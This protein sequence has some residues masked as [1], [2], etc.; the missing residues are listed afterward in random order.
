MLTCDVR[1]TCTERVLPSNLQLDLRLITIQLVP[2]ARRRDCI[3]NLLIPSSAPLSIC[4][5]E[6]SET[7]EEAVAA[8]HAHFRLQKDAASHLMRPRDLET[9][10]TTIMATSS[11]TVIAWQ[12]NS[13]F[14]PPAGSSGI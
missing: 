2:S 14:Q 10:L 9:I 6:A 12:R 13:N 8:E 11:M 7:K 4:A 5:E 1:C 3:Q